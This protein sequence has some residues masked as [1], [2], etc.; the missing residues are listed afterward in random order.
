MAGINA[1]R[2]VTG[3]E[4]IVLRRDQAYIG[5]LLDDLV[6][7]GTTEPYRMFTSRAEYRLVL[8]Q[9]NADL[10]LAPL[11]F[12][13]GL[14]TKQ[15]H[16]RLVTKKSAIDTELCRLSSTHVNSQSLAQLLRRPEVRHQDLPGA[17]SVSDEVS[18]QVE[19]IVKYEGYI[20]RQEAEIERFKG[21]EQKRIPDWIDYFAIHSL[22]SEARQKLTAVKPATL[23]QASRISGISPADLSILAIWMKR[24]PGPQS[25][26][27]LAALAPHNANDQEE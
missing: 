27:A 23:G 8:R 11:G 25:V 20:V 15:N 22:R 24:G 3:S 5:V 14:L 2:R 1:A 9:D 4:P 12:E 21:L 6:T 10:R 17:A 7:K 26:T 19:I 13:L 18:A 16:D